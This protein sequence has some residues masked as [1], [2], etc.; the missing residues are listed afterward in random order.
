MEKMIN[1]IKINSKVPL[2]LVREPETL[3]VSFKSVKN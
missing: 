1:G 3:K 2:V